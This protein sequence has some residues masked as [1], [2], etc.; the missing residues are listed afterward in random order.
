MTESKL[1]I[2]NKQVVVPGQVLAEG[3]EYL[4]SHGTYRKEDKIYANKVGLL[5]I[6]G[7]VLRTISLAGTYLPKRGDLIIGQV[8]DILMSGWRINTNSPYSAILPLKDASFDFIKKGTDLTH[9]FDLEDFV[10]AKITQVTSQN[11]VDVTTKGPGLRRLRG[12]RIIKVNTNKVP[13]IIGK[14]GSMVSMVKKA[15]GCYITVGQNGI[16]WLKGEP[17]KE[18]LAVNAIKKIEEEAH[19]PGLTDRMKNYLEK[20]CGVSLDEELNNNN[21]N[22]NDFEEAEEYKGEE[23]DL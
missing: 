19:V 23:N 16:V 21:E 13:R 14:K 12:G 5:T 3:M 15:T 4:P 1:L 10:V 7:K 17:E 2:E 20:S 11:L 8:T 6:D 9:Y 18:I 22:E